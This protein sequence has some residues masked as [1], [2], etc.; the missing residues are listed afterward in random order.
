MKFF[1][2]LRENS[3]SNINYI[4]YAVG[5]IILVAVGILIALQVNNLNESRI[6][7][8]A[9]KDYFQKIASNI[10]GDLKESE[11]LLK[12]RQD[13]IISCNKA[14][15]SLIES[16]F[17]DQM[18]IQKAIFEMII[19]VQLNYNKDAFESLKSSGYLRYLKNQKLEDL[20][21]DYYS[22]INQIEMFEIDQRN[23]ANALE[24]ELDR[25][26]F[27]YSYTELDQKVHTDL[28]SLLGKY[29]M[30]LKNHPGH[31]IIMRLLFRGGTNNSF[32]TGFYENHIKIGN[33]LIEILNQ[34][35]NH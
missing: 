34:E 18:S 11:R 13:H 10:H 25:N 32:L 6:E 23:W 21:N 8:K 16:N 26:G 7:E 14:S 3:K 17:S 35:I 33:Q 24:L 22:Q 27:F 1:R 20:L 28:F 19:E 31:K 30:E 9:M 12:F 15:K 2:P 5:E 4:K 29:S